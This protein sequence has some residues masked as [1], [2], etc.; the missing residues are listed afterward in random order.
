M[1]STVAEEAKRPLPKTSCL[2]QP[3]GEKKRN[4]QKI[5][6]LFAKIETLFLQ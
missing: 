5:E 4:L 3:V 1:W 2:I 6:T